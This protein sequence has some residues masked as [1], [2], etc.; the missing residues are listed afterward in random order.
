ML[1][2][3]GL[4][5]SITRP[6]HSN[7]RRTVIRVFSANHIAM[8]EALVC[9]FVEGDCRTFR[10]SQA[11]VSLD[12]TLPHTPC[13]LEVAL[14][15]KPRPNNPQP[16]PNHPQTRPNHSPTTQTTSQTT[17]RPRPNHGQRNHQITRPKSP[18]HL[19][20]P[21]NHATNLTSKHLRTVT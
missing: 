20:P 6:H 13:C 4:S 2:N 3:R 7:L 17:P 12:D 19:E 5:N 10:A 15:P 9:T 14:F 11:N 16:R 8:E 1:F 18:Y 21:P